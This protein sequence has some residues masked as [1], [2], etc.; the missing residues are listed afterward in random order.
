MRDEVKAV[1]SE[2]DG[3]R[4]PMAALMY[5]AGL[6]LTERLRALDRELTRGEIIVRDGKG[7]K[8]RATMLPLSLTTAARVAAGCCASHPQARPRR[9]LGSRRAAGG[10][11][12]QVPERPG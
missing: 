6:R 10:P 11:C 8:D 9:R 1:L 4:W 7:G 12:A 5:G 3:E 2:L